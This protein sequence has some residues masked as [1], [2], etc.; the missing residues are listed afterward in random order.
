VGLQVGCGLVS[1][2][3]GRVR[4]RDGCAYAGLVKILAALETV[5]ECDPK[6]PPVAEEVGQRRALLVLRGL[7]LRVSDD[8]ERDEEEGIAES[9]RA[10]ARRS[11][12]SRCRG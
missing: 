7:E 8:G 9:C 10:R 11:G 12:C 1:F 6:L 4:R 5:Y 3:A 2:A